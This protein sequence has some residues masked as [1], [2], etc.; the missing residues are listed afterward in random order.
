[1]PKALEQKQR[2][3]MLRQRRW[4]FVHFARSLEEYK[5]MVR[6]KIVC[7][8][9]EDHYYYWHNLRIASRV[10]LDLFTLEERQIHLKGWTVPERHLR[11]IIPAT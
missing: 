11:K 5:N 1:M 6:A 8:H 10:M 7:Y 4:T 2:E 9:R 3:A